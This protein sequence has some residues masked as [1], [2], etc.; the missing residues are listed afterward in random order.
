MQTDRL[1]QRTQERPQSAKV[2]Y[3]PQREYAPQSTADSVC[4]NC[5][6]RTEQGQR[7]CEDCGYPLGTCQCSN[8][9]QTIEPGLALCPHCGTPTDAS[10]CSFCGEAMDSDEMFCSSC[11]NPRKGIVCPTC[12]TINYRSFCRRCNTP[13]NEL[14]AEA[15]DKA[16]RHPAV[17]RARKL[18]EEMEQ[19][20]AEMEKLMQEA[21]SQPEA[22]G[23]TPD[24]RTPAGQEPPFGDATQMSEDDR[25][26]L[27]RFYRLLGKTP[28][29]PVAPQQKPAT[30]K[31]PATPQQ[32]AKPKMSIAE[33]RKERMKQLLAEYDAKQK[34]MRAAIDAMLPDP[35]DPPE[36][37]RNFLCACLVE[38]YHTT[39]TKKR[40][41][42]EWVC[43]FCGCHHQQPS[44]CCS[45]E[46]GGTW[47]YREVETVTRIKQT[48]TTYW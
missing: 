43:N 35:N 3:N 33:R 20:Q 15:L 17:Q 19:L 34:E 21:E 31:P 6:A 18:N 13:L 7:F 24:D 46:L 25:K 23:G 10:H 38:T 11:G 16:R 28:K 4:P 40:E 8:C 36:E 41:R 14:A 48:V 12:S 26:Q 37:Q 22:G 42:S 2:R 1:L 5:G 39:V 47:I 32:P 29:E 9:H 45:P 30:P 27:E 44:D